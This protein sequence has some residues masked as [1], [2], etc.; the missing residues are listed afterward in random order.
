M[1]S[2]APGDAAHVAAQVQVS[3]GAAVDAQL[4]KA[5]VPSGD[6]PD[7][8]CDVRV[9]PG[10]AAEQVQQTAGVQLVQPQGGIDALRVDKA[11]V[12]AIH[13]GAVVLS[14]DAAGPAEPEDRAGR[15]AG[16]DQPGGFILSRHGADAALAADRAVEE[17]PADRP[18]VQAHDPAHLFAVSGGLHVSADGQ[19][20]D[21]RVLAG[22]QEQ[23]AGGHGRRELQIGDHVPAPVKDAVEH[24]DRAEIQPGHGDIVVQD[25]LSAVGPGVQGTVFRQLREIGGSTDMDLLCRRVG[26]ENCRTARQRQY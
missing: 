6:A 24:R 5:V 11:P 17:A 3:H 21:L 25:H 9:L 4:D 26:G 23:A 18:L 1:P 13:H 10:D 19:Q 2:A 12:F 22:L 16:G 15:A 7:V 14:D 8:G 20:A